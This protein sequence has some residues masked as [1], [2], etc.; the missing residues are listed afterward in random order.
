MKKL[1]VVQLAAAVAMML[2]VSCQDLPPEGATPIVV[3]FEEAELGQLTLEGYNPTT[4]ENVLSGKEQAVLCTDSENQ[5][6]GCMLFDD[7]LYS[8]SG[9]NFGSFYSD[10]KELWGGVFETVYAFVISSNNN[11]EVATV[12]NQY[13]VYSATNGDN[14]FAV[15]YDP[16]WFTPEWQS[17]Y[18]IYDLSTIEFD[19]AVKPLSVKVANSTYNYLQIMQNDPNA[20]LAIKAMG[21]LDGV[22]VSEQSFYLANDGRIVSDWKSVSLAG[23]GTVDKICFTVDWNHTSSKVQSPE[24]WC[25]FGFCIDDLRFTLVK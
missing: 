18:G 20:H 22:Q 21:Y 17:R 5:L 7:I 14:K 23:L 6:N 3:D 1:I 2:C 11:L 15:A 9:A 13:S 8:E 25:P 24:M 10:F 4:Y 16:T 19:E 12:H